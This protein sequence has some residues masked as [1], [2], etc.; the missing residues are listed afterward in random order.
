MVT[1]LGKDGSIVFDKN[2]QFRMPVFS[3]KVIDTMGA[4]DAYFV[5]TSLFASCGSDIDEIALIGNTI[6]SLKTNIRG[7]SKIDFENFF[8]VF[9]HNF[10]INE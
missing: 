7:H 5:V 6:G 10:E 4:G 3:N 1:T 9:K 2:K 8:I